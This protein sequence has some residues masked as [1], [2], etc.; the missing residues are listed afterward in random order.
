VQA[1]VSK[2]IGFKSRRFE[3]EV[4][5]ST[6]RVWLKLNQRMILSDR[7]PIR[8]PEDGLDLGQATA[9]NR[10]QWFPL[11][12]GELQ[13]EFEIIPEGGSMAAPNVQQDIQL[14]QIFLQMVENPY[15]DGRKPMIRALT[16]L[17]EKDPESWLK[18]EAPSVPPAAFEI[19][20]QMVPGL[21]PEAIQFAIAEA[22]RAIRGCRMSS[23][24]RTRSRRSSSWPGR[25]RRERPGA[26]VA[27]G[28]AG[29]GHDGGGP[30]AAARVAVGRGADGPED[31][32]D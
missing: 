24:A 16:L 8:Q 7:D 9:E 17:G 14:A 15:V 28:A 3:I 5:R 21:P 30:V 22:Q 10:W 19:L 27:A 29:G 6:A 13:G 4:V 12:P 26:A 31:A 25:W 23:R 32:R 20:Q 1:A 18:Q 2:R 11:G